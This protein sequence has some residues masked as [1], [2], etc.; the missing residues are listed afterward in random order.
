ME[1]AGVEPAV[2]GLNYGFAADGVLNMNYFIVIKL[3][4]SV[5]TVHEKIG[6]T[7][8]R[9]LTARAAVYKYILSFN[10]SRIIIVFNL[11]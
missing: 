7:I 3:D 5:F 4:L 9:Q 2:Y 11:E 6:K 8:I 1:A 10:L